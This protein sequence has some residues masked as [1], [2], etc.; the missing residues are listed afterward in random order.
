ME[1]MNHDEGNVWR[2]YV[3]LGVESLQGHDVCELVQVQQIGRFLIIYLLRSWY[4]SAICL[5]DG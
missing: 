3:R 5:G 4:S 1:M 2:R